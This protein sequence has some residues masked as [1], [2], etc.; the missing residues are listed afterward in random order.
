V[1]DA[2]T[3]SPEERNADLPQNLNASEREDVAVLESA[4]LLVKRELVPVAKLEHPP[5][6]SVV[7]AIF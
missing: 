2:A 3:T 6:T 4:V 7:V 5:T 1:T